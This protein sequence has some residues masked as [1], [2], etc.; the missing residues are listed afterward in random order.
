MNFKRDHED[1][2]QIFH[3]YMEYMGEEE[4]QGELFTQHHNILDDKQKKK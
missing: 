1:D 2:F 4:K 3:H